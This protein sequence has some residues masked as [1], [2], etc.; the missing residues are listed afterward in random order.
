MRAGAPRLSVVGVAIV[1]A[2]A[3]GVSCTPSNGSSPHHAS[4][5]ATPAIAIASPAVVATWAS[6]ATGA[7]KPHS[8]A[9]DGLVITDVDSGTGKVAQKG[10]LLTVRYIMWLSDARQADS[11][12]AQGSPF[13][14]T[15]GTGM[16]IPG[17]DEGVPGMAVGGTRR[18]VIPPSLA[19]GDRGVA[20]A[21]G[22]Y[23]VPPNTTLVFI[24]QL[25]S[26]AG[27]A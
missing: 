1:S 11:S 22:V 27:P 18:L 23:V 12:D 10:D 4:S 25:V 5:S 17:W 20:N 2:A 7:D 6:F 24:V 15:L 16:V 21:S 13:K 8:T 26:D 14:F 3:L 9:A 19:Y